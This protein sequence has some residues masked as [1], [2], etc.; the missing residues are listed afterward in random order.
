MKFRRLRYLLA[1][2]LLLWCYRGRA[3][4][5]FLRKA[6]HSQE[7][8]QRPD[9]SDLRAPRSSGFF[10][11]HPRGRRFGAGSARAKPA[12]PTCSST[13]PSRAPTRS[14]PRITP[15]RKL[16]SPK[17]RPPMPPT[18]RERD[19]R[20]G[21]RRTK[22]QATGGSLA[23]GRAEAPT[24]TSSPSSSRE[25]LERNG[26]EDMNASH[27]SRTKPT[28]SIRCPA[29]RLELW[30]YLESSASSHPVMREFYK[31]RNVVI[32]ERRMR[33]GQQ[34][35]RT[36][37]RAVHYCRISGAALSSSHHRLDLRPELVFRHRRA[38]VF[39]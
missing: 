27:R 38:A 34:S 16:R 1:V 4:Y 6:H 10:L 29:N 23:G 26:G 39:R 35:D 17:S 36:A 5:R 21:P 25:I 20:S 11:L 31:E 33:V 15:P 14:A 32:E 13:W 7:T 30:A 19:K 12:W 8:R 28:I 9:D 2:P 22:V 24:N 18:S 37:D 3:G